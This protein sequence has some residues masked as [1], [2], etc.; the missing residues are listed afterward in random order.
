MFSRSEDSFAPVCSAVSFPQPYVDY[1]LYDLLHQSCCPPPLPE[2]ETPQQTNLPSCEQRDGVK[3]IAEPPGYERKLAG[4]QSPQHLLTMTFTTEEASR[5]DYVNRIKYGSIQGDGSLQ[6]AL[7]NSCLLQH[8]CLKE[9]NEPLQLHRHAM[10]SSYLEIYSACT[11]LPIPVPVVGCCE[12][13]LASGSQH[14]HPVRVLTKPR[15]HAL[16]GFGSS[17][18]GI[19]T[20]ELVATM[21]AASAPVAGSP[22]TPQ[23]GELPA[24]L[25]SQAVHCCRSV[26]TRSRAAPIELWQPLALP[27]PTPSASEPLR[28]AHQLPVQ[29]PVFTGVQR[30][31]VDLTK[32]ACSLLHSHHD[33]SCNENLAADN[34]NCRPPPCQV[35]LSVVG[36]NVR[37]HCR[38]KVATAGAEGVMLTFCCCVVGSAAVRED[39]VVAMTSWR[40]CLGA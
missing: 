34:R 18:V 25:M 1:A 8:L 36:S 29:Q 9:A 6:F 24:M 2:P 35:Q 13:I 21:T 17:A 37:L 16:H 20:L 23:S 40:A 10:L 32:H 30:D 5:E 7:S 3:A 31:H 11:S 33:S 27:L 38:A 15:L 39:W 26:C 4:V 19:D 14:R 22:V 12:S 28:A